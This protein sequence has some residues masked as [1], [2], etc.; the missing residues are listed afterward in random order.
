LI[1]E[2]IAFDVYLPD[3]AQVDTGS[4]PREDVDFT[5]DGA[6]APYNW[7]LFFHTPF[8]I[9]T[10]LSKNQRFEEAQKWFHYIFDPTATDS[11]DQSGAPGPERFWRVKPFYKQAMD[12]TQTLEDLFEDTGALKA[13][14]KEWQAN[15]FKPHVI[16]KL[17]LVTYMKAVVMR[18]IDNLI[19]WGDQLF[20]RDTIESISISWQPKSSAAARNRFRRGRKPRCR[21]SAPST[22]GQH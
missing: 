4:K 20:R 1:D 8:L 17:R 11:P 9:A 3:D 6:Y 18:Y 22:I 7:E 2:P 13:Q 14:I 16:A 19:A 21:H 5:F 10:Q 12:G 15:P